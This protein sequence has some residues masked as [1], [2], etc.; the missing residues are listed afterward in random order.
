MP[1]AV[2]M[3]REAMG[4]RE[5]VKQWARIVEREGVLY[6]QVQLPPVR[7]TVFQLLL[8]AALQAE[9]LTCLYDNHGHQEVIAILGLILLP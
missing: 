2:E 9:V 5:L 8:P 7:E 4:V 6:R 3:K 1:I